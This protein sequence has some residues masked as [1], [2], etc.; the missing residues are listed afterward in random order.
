[1]PDDKK[2]IE[3]IDAAFD[4]VAKSLVSKPTSISNNFNRL[5]PKVGDLVPP[6]VQGELF[7]IEKQAEVDGIEMGV[8]ENGM[9]YLTESGLARMCGIDRKVLNRLAANWVEERSKPRGQKIE[10]L[11]SEGGFNGDKLS[12]PSEHRG[13]A[14]SAYPEPVCLALLEYYAFVTDEPREQAV[15][16]FRTLAKTTFR[17]FIYSAVGYQP[18]QQAIDSWKHFHDRIDM[19]MDSVPEGYFSIFREIASMIVPMIRSNI[20]ISDKVIPDISVGKA[21]SEYWKANGLYKY[22]D[23]IRYDHEYPL[24]YPQAKSNPQP[25]FAYPEAIIGIFRA[26][27]R[28][29]YITNKLPTY[30]TGQ[31]KKGALAHHTATKV[32]ESFSGKRLEGPK[33]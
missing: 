23:R 2:I 6:P 28:R 11:L 9:P 13:S 12:L 18:N 3:P 4:D 25:A 10:D 26:W 17:A 32:I 7:H 1:M 24:Y 14:I 29:E 16:A 30:L 5:A 21:W 8:L 19:T 27:L 20:I 22:G 15:R 31:I 33:D